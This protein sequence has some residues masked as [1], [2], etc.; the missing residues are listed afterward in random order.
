MDLANW[1]VKNNLEYVNDGS[2]THK[3][4]TSG[5]ED[6]IDLS[7]IT[8]EAKRLMLDGKYIKI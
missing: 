6:V 4:S 5:K 7:M 2:P 1:M 3:N 8:M